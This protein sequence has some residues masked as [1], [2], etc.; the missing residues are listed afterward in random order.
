[1]R[2]PGAD[3][4]LCCT[5]RLLTEG[6]TRKTKTKSEGSWTQSLIDRTCSDDASLAAPGFDDR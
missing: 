4:H 5:A 2:M 1:M 6:E 3:M